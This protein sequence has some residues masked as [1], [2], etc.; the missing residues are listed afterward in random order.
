MPFVL[1]NTIT[2]GIDW[3][4][5]T[6]CVSVL[7]HL[8]HLSVFVHFEYENDSI[9]M[10]RLKMSEHC[11]NKEYEILGF[12]CFSSFIFRS[13]PVLFQTCGA[14]DVEK[15]KQNEIYAQHICASPICSFFFSLL[16]HRVAFC[17]SQH[18]SLI[19]KLFFVHNLFW[20]EISTIHS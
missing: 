8:K 13:I 18:S 17:S 20:N 16:H 10:C 4:E 7:L 3:H 9:A 12:W 6:H 5:F 19:Y 15:W 1:Q 2:K 14:F 11:I